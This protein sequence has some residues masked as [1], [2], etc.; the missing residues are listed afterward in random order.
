[1]GDAIELGFLIAVEWWDPGVPGA[2]W[3]S[4]AAKGKVSAFTM[5]AAGMQ[6]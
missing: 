2:K 3:Q 4:L 6:W 5:I 1:M